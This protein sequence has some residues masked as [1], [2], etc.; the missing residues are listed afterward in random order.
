V[1]VCVSATRRL[2]SF[3]L[4]CF[5]ASKKAGRDC[6]IEVTRNNEIPKKCSEKEAPFV[7]LPLSHSLRFLILSLEI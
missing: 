7:L 4:A 3:F 5:A 1:N 6:S 2:G